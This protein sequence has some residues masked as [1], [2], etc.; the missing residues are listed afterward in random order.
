MSYEQ[1]IDELRIELESLPDFDGTLVFND[2]LKNNGVKVHN[3]TITTE[4]NAVAPCIPM[5]YFYNEYKYENSITEIA[6]KI[7]DLYCNRPNI[8]K[9]SLDFSWDKICDKVFMAL[10]NTASNTDLL[11]KIPHI[12]FLDWSIIFK[13]ESPIPS[14]SGFITITNRLFETF[15]IS[16]TD[17]FEYAYTNTAKVMPPQLLRLSDLTKD[18][19]LFKDSFFED[20]F[21]MLT[22]SE[23]YYGAGAILCPEVYDMFKE[24]GMLDFYLLPSSIHEFMIVRPMGHN[25]ENSL[26]EMIREVNGSSYVPETDY[27]GDHTIVYSKL[28]EA[29]NELIARLQTADEDTLNSIKEAEE[30]IDEIS[31]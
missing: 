25:Q 28:I 6:K 29:F 15:E 22:N 8:E 10:I 1:F 31:E 11:E 26:N 4:D 3:L 14:L 27:L 17:L 9:S 16:I 12:E 5:D 20:S 30:R 18:P 2:S 13:L 23:K 24:K 7:Y 19:E 21:W